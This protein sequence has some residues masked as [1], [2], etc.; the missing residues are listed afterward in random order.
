MTRVLKVVNLSNYDGEDYIVNGNYIKPGEAVFVF[1]QYKQG[2]VQFTPVEGGETVP[3]PFRNE[4]GKQLVPDM[5]LS[6]KE[7]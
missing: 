1:D 6:F 5:Q 7:A 4:D 3:M 2:Y